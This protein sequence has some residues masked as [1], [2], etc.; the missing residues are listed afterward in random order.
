M[1][2][3]ASSRPAPAD[4]RRAAA[5]SR[6]QRT[7]RGILVA[8]AGIGVLVW[9]LVAGATATT[10]GNTAPS[11]APSQLSQAARDRFFDNARSSGITQQPTIRAPVLRSHG[12]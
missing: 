4:P 5:D 3:F 10:A 2:S 12:S 6:L 9:S 1:P 11:R 8:S 7:K